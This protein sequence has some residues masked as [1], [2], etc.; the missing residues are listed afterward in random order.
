M[1][2]KSKHIFSKVEGHRPWLGILEFITGSLALSVLGDFG[3][4]SA[5][6]ALGGLQAGC[7]YQF[8]NSN[9]VFGIQGDYDWTNASNT[10]A[11]P[12]FPS[13]TDQT[14]IKSLSSITGR[15]GYT[16]FGPKFLGYVKAGGAWSKGTSLSRSALFRS[17]RQTRRKAAGQ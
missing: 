6:G 8:V 13:V 7:N 2:H 11:V 15:I 14:Q 16:F 9:W 4:N 17:R 10:S 12:L 5:T 1:L 3:S